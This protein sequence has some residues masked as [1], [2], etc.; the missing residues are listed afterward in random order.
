[1]KENKSE[2][3]IEEVKS[4]KMFLDYSDENGVRSKKEMSVKIN[5]AVLKDKSQLNYHHHKPKLIYTLSFSLK[6]PDHIHSFLRG[7]TVPAFGM[8]RSKETKEYEEDFSKTITRESIEA[9][10][11]WWHEVISDYE[12]LKELDKAKL[13]KVIFYGFEDTGSSNWKSSWNGDEYGK[14]STLKYNYCI[15]Y[16]SNVSGKKQRYNNERILMSTSYHPEYYSLSFVEWTEERQMFFDNIQ[17]SFEDITERIKKFNEG[18]SEK[19]INH[20]ISNKTLL[21]GS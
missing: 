1:M 19:T 5:T 14:E 11:T 8:N 16:V 15:G 13:T 6:I 9:L 7:K 3:P 12:Y 20:I 4:I 2:Q 10:T 18:L 21:L 17:K